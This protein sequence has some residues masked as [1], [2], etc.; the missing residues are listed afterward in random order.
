MRLNGSIRTCRLLNRNL[1][2]I[3][4]SLMQ[5]TPW[6]SLTQILNQIE[7]WLFQ[8]QTRWE[9]EI[10]TLTVTFE[11]LVISTQLESKRSNMG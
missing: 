1:K 9:T 6:Q 11:R 4:S 8:S 3:H 5:A 10:S 2:E 7:T